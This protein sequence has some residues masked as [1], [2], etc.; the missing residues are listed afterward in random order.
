MTKR[1]KRLEKQEKSLLKQA[2]EH[3]RKQLEL[4]GRKDTTKGYWQREE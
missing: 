2:E 3:K 4:K 1:K